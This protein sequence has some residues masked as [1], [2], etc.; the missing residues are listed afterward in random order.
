MNIE[1]PLFKQIL[2]CA[3]LASGEPMPIERFQ[4]LFPEEEK[5]TAQ[6]IRQVLEHVA[7]ECESRGLALKEVAS[8]FSLQISSELKPWIARLWEKR[9]PRYSRALLETLALVAYRQPITRSEI[10]DIRGVSVSSHI[11]KTLMERD[12]VRI[13]GHKDVPGKPALYATTKSFLDYFNLKTLDELP[14]LPEL[15]QAL[16]ES[17]QIPA[18]EALLEHQENEI[19]DEDTTT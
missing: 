15:T 11:F 18:P 14:T 8:G 6:E 17:I 9:P 13:V 12:W 2:E 7:T 10:E 1:N 3:L 16:A 5:P 19:I 4:Q